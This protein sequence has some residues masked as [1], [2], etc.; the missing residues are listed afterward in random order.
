MLLTL[1]AHKPLVVSFR[2]A[3]RGFELWVVYAPKL[4]ARKKAETGVSPLEMI[5]SLGWLV[6][7]QHPELAKSP[8]IEE[9]EKYTRREDELD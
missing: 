9:R 7:R 6:I 5:Y 1:Q 2:G 3:A 8:C 4:Q